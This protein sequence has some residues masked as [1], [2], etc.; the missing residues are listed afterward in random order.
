M[1]LQDVPGY[2]KAG[3]RLFSAPWLVHEGQ[4]ICI[5]CSII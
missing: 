3:R 4:V 5:T 1:I 2:P